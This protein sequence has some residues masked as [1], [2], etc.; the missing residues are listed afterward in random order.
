MFRTNTFGEK[1]MILIDFGLATF[2]GPES[3]R[4]EGKV[5]S[6]IIGTPKFAS[7]FVHCG[8]EYEK[9]DDL[10]SAL[11]LAIWIHHGDHIWDSIVEL[12]NEDGIEIQL[13]PVYEKTKTHVDHPMNVWL[14][15]AKSKANVARLCRE[16]GD[17]WFSRMVDT[18][19][20]D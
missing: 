16:M 17:A 4:E 19:Y 15:R 14:K 6:N 7:W 8:R 3:V 20:A 1:E 12:E 5:H 13:D 11:Y 9:R 18:L 2:L 10:L